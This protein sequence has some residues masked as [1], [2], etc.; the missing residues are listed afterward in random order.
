[1]SCNSSS[2]A[3]GLASAMAWPVLVA[4]GVVAA[5]V[6]HVTIGVE[7]RVTDDALA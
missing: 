2:T 3:E 6:T 4:L 1:M 7:R 5:L